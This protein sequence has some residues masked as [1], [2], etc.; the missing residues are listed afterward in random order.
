LKA[1][2]TEGI[3]LS[4]T[5]ARLQSLYGDAASLQ[6]AKDDAGGTVVTVV[7]PAER[8]VHEAR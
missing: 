2:W 6:L 4:N 3:G 5:R 8:R 7:V 1:G